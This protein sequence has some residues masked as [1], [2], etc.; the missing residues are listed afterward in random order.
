MT[1]AQGHQC[2]SKLRRGRERDRDER[3]KKGKEKEKGFP[4]FRLQPARARWCSLTRSCSLAYVLA[5]CTRER[6]R[7]CSHTSANER[8]FL[9]F[10]TSLATSPLPILRSSLLSLPPSFPPSGPRGRQEA[11]TAWQRALL[12]INF[13]PSSAL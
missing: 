11:V 4:I 12:H 6:M 3:M 5:L 2:F 9:S 1:T 8:G 13:F 7:P 10:A